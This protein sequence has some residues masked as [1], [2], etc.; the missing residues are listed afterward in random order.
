MRDK[1]RYA[2]HNTYTSS[3]LW[4]KAFED[5]STDNY[6]IDFDAWRFDD[7]DQCEENCAEN[8]E[9]NYGS[10]AYNITWK[11]DSK[12]GQ[13]VRYQSG[14]KHRDLGG[15]QIVADTIIIQKVNSKV[16]D[17]EGRLNIDTTGSGEAIIFRDGYKI[18]ARWEKLD[19]ES[20]TKW[21]DEDGN[22]IG[23]KPGKIWM[24]IVDQNTKLEVIE[25]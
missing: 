16:V 24:E 9:I 13:Y 21:F 1:N 2:P 22:E 15:D 25:K 12:K 10:Y 6:K 7:K 20:R 8:I 19:I 11:F 4:K 14:S 5:Y 23:L 18:D 3:K 17:S